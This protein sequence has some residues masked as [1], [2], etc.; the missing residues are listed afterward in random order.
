MV[1]TCPLKGLGWRFP[2]I[3]SQAIILCEPLLL[4]YNLGKLLR[5]E[6]SDR[7]VSKKFYQ[8]VVQT[9]L[10]LGAE[11]WVL[12]ATM[13]QNLKVVHV[14][15]LRQVAGIMSRKLGADKQKKEGEETVLQATG[16]KPLW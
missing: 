8:G 14:G 9:V 4:Q 5:R 13:L 10:L 1:I 2:E 11:T 6:G 16:T 7:I 3:Y 15:F 12:R